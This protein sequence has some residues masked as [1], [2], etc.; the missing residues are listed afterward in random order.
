[1]SLEEII[2]K[3]ITKVI[4]EQTTKN[5]TS[6]AVLALGILS[7]IALITAGSAIFVIAPIIKDQFVD[8]SIEKRIAQIKQLPQ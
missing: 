7:S 3:E 4:Q 8:K 1:M 2:H 5:S 6:K